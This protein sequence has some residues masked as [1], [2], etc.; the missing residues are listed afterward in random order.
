[1]KHSESLE[2]RY[3]YGGEKRQSAAGYPLL[4]GEDRIYLSS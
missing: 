4:G 2:R 1:M 3:A